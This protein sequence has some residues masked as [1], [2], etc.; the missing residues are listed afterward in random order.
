MKSEAAAVRH[1][2]IGLI[3]KLRLTKG[4]YDNLKRKADQNGQSVITAA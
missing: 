4:V 3:L 2:F 1:G